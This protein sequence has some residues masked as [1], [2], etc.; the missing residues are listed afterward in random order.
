MAAGK[1]DKVV[2][3]GS[4]CSGNIMKLLPLKLYDVESA[5]EQ[6]QMADDFDFGEQFFGRFALHRQ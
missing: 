2:S 4:L 5:F 3:K 1:I 6:S